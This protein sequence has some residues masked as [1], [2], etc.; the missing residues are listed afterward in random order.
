MFYI[1]LTRDKWTGLE[2]VPNCYNNPKQFKTED[3]AIKY[4]TEMEIFPFEII[5]VHI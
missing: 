4:A 5:S 1:I 3:E 2:V